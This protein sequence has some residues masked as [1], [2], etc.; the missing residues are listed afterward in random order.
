MAHANYSRYC[1]YLFLFFF[2]PMTFWNWLSSYQNIQCLTFL[3][4]FLLSFFLLTFPEN[5]GL[6]MCCIT[7]GP[8]SK[9]RTPSLVD[10]LTFIFINLT[11]FVGEKNSSPQLHNIHVFI[12]DMYISK[13]Y[14]RIRET[15]GFCG[16]NDVVGHKIFTFFVRL[17]QNC[18]RCAGKCCS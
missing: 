10:I 2:L 12:K 1:I 4:N 7:H 13:S 11:I 18:I 6:L 8:F 17:N 3:C 9:Q 5:S 15:N 14:A 16:I